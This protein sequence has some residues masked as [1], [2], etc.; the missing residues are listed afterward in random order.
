MHARS[1]TSH[2]SVVILAA[3]MGTRLSSTI[4]KVLVEVAGRPILRRQVD[5]LLEWFPS[6][7][8][9]LVV[10]YKKELVM[11]LFPEMA[12]AYNEGYAKTNTARSLLKGMGRVRAGH[13]LWMNGDVVFEEAVLEMLLETAADSERS[14]MLVDTKPCGEEEVKYTLDLMGRITSV[15]KTVTDGVGEALGMNIVLEQDMPTLID[16]LTKCGQ[17]DYFEAAIQSHIDAGGIWLPADRG[18]RFCVEIDFPEDLTAAETAMRARD[19]L[20]VAAV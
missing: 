11:E 6:E 17:T 19:E 18:D 1:L 10:G 16:S 13:C 5:L 20:D 8:I 9:T 12:F 3:G 15:S 2:T 7:A 14:T 4:P